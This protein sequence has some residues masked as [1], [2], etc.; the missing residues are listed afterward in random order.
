[1]KSFSHFIS[2]SKD[3]L[4]WR[5]RR[6]VHKIGPPQL[7]SK[8]KLWRGVNETSGKNSARY[9]L[10]LYTTTSMKHAKEF[11]KVSEMPFS[12]LPRNALIFK[13]EWN[14]EMFEQTLVYDILGAKVRSDVKDSFDK[15]VRKH[16][17][18]DIDGVQ[19][20]IGHGAYFV[21]WP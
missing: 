17:D 7:N 4:D 12:S 2:E 10:G 14:W 11:G 1:M 9:G 5:L 3:D 6:Y 18:K 16:V 21:K 19:I 13:T 15:L 20:G 8:M